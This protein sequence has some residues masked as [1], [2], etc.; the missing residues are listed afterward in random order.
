MVLRRTALKLLGLGLELVGVHD[1]GLGLGRN[2][3]V[4]CLV[5]A[6]PVRPAAPVGV[7]AVDEGLHVDWDA[8]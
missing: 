7:D 1:H 2:D 6:L 4:Q 5:H 8:W 3:I